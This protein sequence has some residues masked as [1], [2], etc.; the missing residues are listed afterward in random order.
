[1]KTLKK[2][3]MYLTKV[4]LKEFLFLILINVVIYIQNFKK[5]LFLPKYTYKYQT[6]RILQTVQQ[7]T[8]I[9]INSVIGRCQQ[10][11]SK[12]CQIMLIPGKILIQKIITIR[13]NQCEIS[14]QNNS[15]QNSVPIIDFKNTNCIETRAKELPYTD[16][17][18]IGIYNC[19][20]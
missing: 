20:A 4:T 8:K 2:W 6:H 11:N 1:M 16:N 15:L 7:E 18:C 5:I 13:E 9:I 3:K 14:I 10:T 17:L 12:L 19:F